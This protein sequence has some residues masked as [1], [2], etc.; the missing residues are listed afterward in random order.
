MFGTNVRQNGGV[1]INDWRRYEYIDVAD[2]SQNI[3]NLYA[4]MGE[5]VNLNTQALEEQ[6][7]W[8]TC[9]TGEDSDFITTSDFSFT[10]H[11][12]TLDYFNSDTDNGIVNLYYVDDS[13]V[14]LISNGDSVYILKPTYTAINI[15]TSSVTGL[16]LYNYSITY[17]LSNSN[18]EKI[19]FDKIYLDFPCAV[20]LKPPEYSAGEFTDL[21]F[22]RYTISVSNPVLV[23]VPTQEMVEQLIISNAS[24]DD[25]INKL[26]TVNSVDQA[27]IDAQ[28]TAYS[29]VAT[30]TGSLSGMTDFSESLSSQVDL[31]QDVDVLSDAALIDSVNNMWDLFPWDS[32]F[33]T[34]ALG[35]IASI[36]LLSLILHGGERAIFASKGSNRSKH[37][38]SSNKGSGG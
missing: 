5:K 30:V 8:L 6:V 10:V 35:M 33:F 4:S 17:S 18:N 36:A 7:V 21:N 1:P 14:R 25:L 2:P 20:N 27:R 32:Q 26:G 38:N 31:S 12:S 19:E 3:I 11:L 37:S 16:S 29:E 9:S 24:N 34:V 15:V 23:T 13:R 22:S 28:K